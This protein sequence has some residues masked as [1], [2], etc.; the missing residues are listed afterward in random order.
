[1]AQDGKG[2]QKRKKKKKEQD[3]ALEMLRACTG[4]ASR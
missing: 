2:G 4:W 3:K 1:M